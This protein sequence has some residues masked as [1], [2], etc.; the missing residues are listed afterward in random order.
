MIFRVIVIL[1]NY[2]F[3]ILK[4]FVVYHMASIASFCI[5]NQRNRTK[6]EL[7]LFILY[8]KFM[9][10]GHHLNLRIASSQTPLSYSGL[11][12]KP[13]ATGFE[14]LGH[15]YSCGLHALCG[16]RVNKTGPID[17]GAPVATDSN[18]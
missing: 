13:Q 16:A 10:S 12:R 8:V 14:S 17:Y 1:C 4:L 18:S 3:I 7:Q 5:L 6:I 9:D 2:D 11:Y 15:I